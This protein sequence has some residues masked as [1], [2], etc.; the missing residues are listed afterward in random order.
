MMKP[1]GQ[2]AVMQIGERNGRLTA[3]KFIEHDSARQR[4]WLF[5]CECGGS[6]VTRTGSVRSGH[7]QSCG[8]QKIESATSH[9]MSRSPE[10]RA[11]GAIFQRC[12]NPKNKS[13]K[14]YGARGITICE[15]WRTFE[16]FLADMG[17]RPSKDH[18]ID[19]YP[20]NDDG[21]KPSNCRW[22]TWDEQAANRRKQR[23]CRGKPIRG[24]LEACSVDP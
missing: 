21:Y 12:V 6:V 19:R 9:G 24:H 20:D 22:A 23:T 11:W 4:L 16:N 18:S 3:E 8:C 1:R 17:P 5:R 2:Y 7:T 15:R 13:F 14:N 10:Y